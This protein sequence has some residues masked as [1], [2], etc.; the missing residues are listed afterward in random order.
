MLI[1]KKLTAAEFSS[2]FLRYD[3]TCDCIQFTPDGGETWIDQPANDPRTS[4]AYRLPALTGDNT[5]C[6][7]AEGMRALIEQFVNERIETDTALELAGGILGIIAFIPGFNVL[8]ALILAFASLAVTIARELLEAAFTEE[9]YDAIRCTLYCHID[10][11]GQMS[12]AQFDAAYAEFD[13]DAIYP[14]AITQLWVHA[15][16]DLVGPV[17]MSDAGVSLEAAADCDCDCGWC[18]EFDFTIGD[19][20]WSPVVVSGTDFAVYSSGV[21]W[22]AHIQNDGCSDHAYIYMRFDFGATIDNLADATMDFTLPYYEGTVHFYDQRLSG[23]IA[24]RQSCGDMITSPQSVTLT[25]VPCDQLD[26]TINSCNSAGGMTI[27]KL[28][29]RGFGDCPFGTPNCD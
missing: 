12:Q 8:W 13:D 4:D 24:S 11:N 2:P 3:E 19:G 15:V 21:G 10:E 17:G 9:I 16:M 25:A 23:S 7:A 28:T 27:T 18:Y 14:N 20:G 1:R 29:F 26:V 6:R 5:R 22:T